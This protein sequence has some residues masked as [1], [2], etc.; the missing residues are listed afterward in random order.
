MSRSGYDVVVV[1]LGAVGVAA[2][3]HLAARGQRVLGLDRYSI[4][5]RMGS[6]HGHSRIIRFA[7]FEDPSYVPL[8]YRAA[9]LWRELERTTDRG[10]FVVT[11]SL[12]IGRP[13][14]RVVRG[15]L[16]ACR[17]HR[18]QHELL[19]AAAV[20]V[21][22]PA[23]R[24][25]DDMV[26]VYQPEGGALLPEA[27]IEAHAASA[28]AAGAE[29]HAE[30]RVLEWAPTPAGVRVRSGRATYE[31][32][33]L[34]VCG[35]AWASELLPFLDGL[36]RPE[37]QVLGWFDT[38]A[39]ELFAPNRLPVI[40]ADVDEGQYYAFPE[41]AVPGFKIG[42]FHHLG[43]ATSADGVD[44]EVHAED[45]EVL[46]GFCRHYVPAASGPLL[47]SAVCMFT[48]SPDGHFIVDH[49]PDHDQVTLFAGGSGH[50]FKFASALGEM[51][52]VM[53]GGARSEYQ[54]PLFH[55]DRFSAPG[56]LIN[57]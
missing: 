14:S 23:L 6:S 13:E 33:R 29:L 15:A 32:E 31:A 48:N 16:E 9:R 25:D 40:V 36:A 11:G 52:A 4:P 47:S 3:H 1:G 42:R 5:N 20:A 34:V 30:E 21:R 2:A 28:V 35:G 56:G 18:L 22:H 41:I 54:N 26:G 17:V 43:Q 50:A 8:A 24:L 38:S 57:E 19:D 55:L 12:D 7:Y 45:E 39:P 49:D 37:R 51:V 10:L 46:R 53:S 44:R 27:C